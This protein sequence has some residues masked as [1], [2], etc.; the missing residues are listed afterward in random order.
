M[1]REDLAVDRGRKHQIGALANPL[2][3]RLERFRGGTKA[4]A[5]DD[6]ETPTRRKAGES[7]KN[8]LAG[9]LPKPTLDMVRSRKRRV[10]HD[11]RGRDRPI[12]PVVDRRGIVIRPD[13]LR[14]QMS[15]QGTAGFCKFVERQPRACNSGENRQ[16]AGA[17]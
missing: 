13:S 2:K 14:K 9:G 16:Q 7:R 12:Q 10:H 3:R 15:Q 4:L 1:P 11:D 8:V 5:S 17:G 6:N